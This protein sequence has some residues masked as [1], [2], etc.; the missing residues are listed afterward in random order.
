MPQLRAINPAAVTHITRTADILRAEN[1]LLDAQAA[2]LL[3]P[4]G[5]TLPCAALLS[6]PEALRPRMLRLLTD[7]LGAGKKRT[8]PP[9]TTGR[10]RHW[11]RP[12]ARFLCPAARPPSAVTVP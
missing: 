7:R 4:E 10:W 12:A 1:D 8:S 6:A 3:P 9:P 5:T 11:H 2:A